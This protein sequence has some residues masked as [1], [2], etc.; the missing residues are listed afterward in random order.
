MMNPGSPLHRFRFG[1][2]E[3]DL[4]GCELRK[5]G[6]RI[7]LQEKP[8]QLLALLLE[9]PG[10]LMSR[11]E[12]CDKLWG[13]DTFVDFNQGLN[14][15]VKKLR[16]ALGDTAEDPHYIETQPRRGYRFIGELSAYTPESEPTNSSETSIELIKVK[17][18][19][20]SLPA[21]TT[22]QHQ[23][24]RKW[25][26]FPLA[27]ILLIA[28]TALYFAPFQKS[29]PGSDHIGSIVVLPFVNLNHDPDQEYLSDELTD[30]LIT[31]L[32][33]AGTLR[34]ISRTSA[35]EYKGAHKR[36][37]QIARELH[38]DTA[39]EGSVFRS[40]NRVRINAKLVRAAT[41]QSLFAET[42]EGDLSDVLTLQNRICTAIAHRIE[43]KLTPWQERELSSRIS[44]DAEVYEAYL[45]GRFFWNKRSLE[46]LNRAIEYFQE[47]ITKDPRSAL[48]YAGLADCFNMLSF[49]EG[50]TPRES[51]PQARA[52][53]LKA[54]ELDGDL[55]EAHAALAFSR[56]HYDWDW[57]SAESEFRRALILNPNYSNA[58]HWYSHYLLVSGRSQDALTETRKALELDPLSLSINTHLGH[59]YL[60][61]RNYDKAIAQLRQTL[62]MDRTAV[63]AHFWLGRAYEA[64]GQYEEAVRE[65]RQAMELSPDN[66]QHRAGLG[67]VYAASGQVSAARQLLE[68]LEAMPRGKYTSAYFLAVVY[69]GLNDRQK[70]LNHLRRAYEER[71]EG[72]LYL[73]I[74][75]YFDG[76]RSD[77]EFKNLV[78]GIRPRS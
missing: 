56:L 28:G 3:L 4:R 15:A 60:Y 77:S 46:G 42:Y 17:E 52:A 78:R 14:T 73:H 70:A 16:Q 53:A 72:V 32:A 74:D 12:L 50:A 75:P 19:I 13:M 55:G 40:G 35:M 27:A 7:K 45:K 29:S 26:V 47:A 44:S 30:V 49:Y 66:V 62:E 61:T 36:L 68:E 21:G 2:F 37:P 57:K 76:L 65:F 51:F 31:G 41:D 54:L 6:H 33:R 20:K 5:C 22:V 8:F 25:Q 34:V 64:K 9:R 63:Q 48:A 69:A 38:V 39:L 18:E 24:G 58:R 10:E 43:V 23:Y 11:D 59:H 1:K 71:A 67:H